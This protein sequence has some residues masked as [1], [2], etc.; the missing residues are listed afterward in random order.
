MAADT[1]TLTEKMRAALRISSTSEKITEEI[2]DCIAAC[3]MDLQDV[4]V[5]KLEETDALIIRAIPL[6]LHTRRAGTLQTAVK[7]AAFIMDAA[8][9]WTAIYS[10]LMAAAL[11][12]AQA[13]KAQ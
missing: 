5:K 8:A 1:T 10:R 3:K 7:S 12:L 4:G 13:G 2:N 11:F 9:R 6:T